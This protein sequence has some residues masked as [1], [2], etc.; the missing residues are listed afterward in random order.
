MGKEGAAG[1]WLD[2]TRGHS[3][4]ESRSMIKE[5]GIL[6]LLRPSTTRFMRKTIELGHLFHDPLWRSC[7][8]S[9]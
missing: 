1:L 3:T 7:S 8:T 6:V 9:G 2:G 4:F 5:Y